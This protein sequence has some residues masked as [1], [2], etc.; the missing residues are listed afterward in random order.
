MASLSKHHEELV[1]G[2]GKCS[3]PMWCDDIPGGF[4]DQLAYGER[5]PGEE[6]RDAHT[7]ELKRRD[8]KFNGYVPG[9]ACPVHGGPTLKDVEGSKVQ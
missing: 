6:W 4:C 7:G 2:R 5:P 1:D 9:L 3:V 8:G